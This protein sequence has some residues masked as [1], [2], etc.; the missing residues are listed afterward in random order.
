MIVTED[1]GL[2]NAGVKENQPVL[3]LWQEIAAVD[4][5]ANLLILK[6]GI[7]I[8]LDNRTVRRVLKNWKEW[9]DTKVTT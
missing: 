7:S 9:L 5:R 4:A 3:W 8:E 1:Y 2:V 6:G